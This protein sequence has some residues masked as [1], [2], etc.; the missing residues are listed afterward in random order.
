MIVLN[1]LDEMWEF[2]AGLEN[3]MERDEAGRA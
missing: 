2:L 1:L 3:L